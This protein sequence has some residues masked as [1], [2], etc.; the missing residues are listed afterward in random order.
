MTYRLHYWRYGVPY[1]S[2][3]DTLAR[4]MDKSTWLTEDSEDMP[5]G[6][7]MPVYISKDGNALNVCMFEVRWLHLDGAPVD[8]IWDVE[9]LEDTG[10]D[11][12]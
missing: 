9:W 12:D 8:A 3:H 6:R 1:Y 4:A 11:D 5:Y 10:S 2:D 7:G